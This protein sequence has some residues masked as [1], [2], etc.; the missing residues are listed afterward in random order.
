VKPRDIRLR[1]S[2]VRMVGGQ[3]AK[4]QKTTTHVSCRRSKA[5]W[6]WRSHPLPTRNMGA[7]RDQRSSSA[8]VPRSPASFAWRFPGLC[9]WCHL[10]NELGENV[11]PPIIRSAGVNVE[12][13]TYSR[14]MSKGSSATAKCVI[15]VSSSM[16]RQAA[17]NGRGERADVRVAGRQNVRACRSRNARALVPSPGRVYFTRRPAKLTN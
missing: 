3:S 17:S 7:P 5:R 2:I 11:S 4:N 12:S 15:E 8:F 1:I 10:T 13:H 16:L 9:S 6:T 14:W